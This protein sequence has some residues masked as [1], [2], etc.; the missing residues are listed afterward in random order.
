[1]VSV[2]S[3]ENKKI[4]LK[5]I[6]K[7]GW[8]LD[9]KAKLRFN[10][11]TSH[12][13]TIKILKVFPGL[14]LD[15]EKALHS[16][17]SH[18]RFPGTSEWYEDC[19]EIIN[20][21]Y[22]PDI[23]KE[24]KEME[25]SE[26]VKRAAWEKKRPTLLYLIRCLTMNDTSSLESIPNEEEFWEEI[27]ILYPVEK[28]KEKEIT[29]RSLPKDLKDILQKLISLKTIENKSKL[30]NSISIED[31]EHISDLG[32]VEREVEIYMTNGRK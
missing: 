17:F 15:V 31:F 9:K 3:E 27:K 30:L 26:S 19:E 7:I 29:L 5:T 23:K 22:S 8:T 20:F 6:L 12:N 10:T 13:P 25:E 11:Y 16:R 21:F 14:S 32:L 1:M 2:S 4:R 24:L 18:I 28:I